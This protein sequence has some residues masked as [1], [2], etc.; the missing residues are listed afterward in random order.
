MTYPLV[1][2]PDIYLFKL[3]KRQWFSLSII[4][5]SD[6]FSKLQEC[7]STQVGS[8]T[9]LL[10]G[11]HSETLHPLC[12]RLVFLPSM[13]IRITDC[14][15]LVIPLVASSDHKPISLSSP[16]LE[17]DKEETTESILTG[18]R[19]ETLGRRCF[20]LGGGGVYFWMCYFNTS[21]MG[22]LPSSLCSSFSSS[23]SLV[24]NISQQSRKRPSSLGLNSE[25]KEETKTGEIT[26]GKPGIVI[27][28]DSKRLKEVKTF[29]ESHS[30]YDKSRKI[31]R[32]QDGVFAVPI[33]DDRQT[34]HQ[35]Q[36]LSDSLQAIMTI[37]STSTGEMDNMIEA[38]KSYSQK[39]EVDRRIQEWCEKGIM[40]IM[41]LIFRR[42]FLFTTSP[43]S[44][45]S[46][47]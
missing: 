15:E 36:H 26:A 41:Y 24:H 46:I 2:S 47:R 10:F 14:T 33:S 9:Y 37:P 43:A 29:L 44:D 30:L 13:Q 38:K 40:L 11:V 21:L 16:S 6:L 20:L 25:T 4:E 31:T 42:I 39:G 19:V 7:H 35:F 1:A 22:D 12:L 18:F 32:V 23:C 34:H 8:N 5:G 45:R 17:M 28:R 3:S 27:V